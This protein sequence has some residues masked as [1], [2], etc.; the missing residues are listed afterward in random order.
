MNYAEQ[1][2]SMWFQYFKNPTAYLTP[3]SKY[4]SFTVRQ[5]SIFLPLSGNGVS[6]KMLL[7]HVKGI[8]SSQE[9]F[10]QK[11]ATCTYTLN[12]LRV[13]QAPYLHTLSLQTC[14]RSSMDNSVFNS[15]S[16]HNLHKSIEKHHL[17]RWLSTSFFCWI[18]N[19]AM[20]GNPY[21]VRI[22][23]GTIIL[24]HIVTA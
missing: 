17:K 7:P 21:F 14:F 22:L 3:A 13:M 10:S 2:L 5:F 8:Q 20:F 11:L 1:M 19:T 9:I 4:T 18:L 12:D 23:L 6:D 24:S 16:L 15:V